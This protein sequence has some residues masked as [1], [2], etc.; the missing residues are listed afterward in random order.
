MAAC[1]VINPHYFNLLLPLSDAAAQDAEGRTA[2]FYAVNTVYAERIAALA[3]LC[4]ANHQDAD[5]RTAL[6][7]AVNAGYAFDD[8]VVDLLLDLSDARLKDNKGMDAA[9]LALDCGKESL[10]NRIAAVALSQEDREQLR[11][12]TGRARSGKRAKSKSI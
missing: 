5:G 12:L 8:A 3:K 9:A 1:T 4:N 7:E 6:M 11:G 2:L 10:S